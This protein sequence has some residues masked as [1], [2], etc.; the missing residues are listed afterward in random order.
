MRMCVAGLALAAALGVAGV[1]SAQAAAALTSAVPISLA[2]GSFAGL[3]TAGQARFAYVDSGLAEVG[4]VNGDGLA[5]VA[6]GAASADAK[7]R[8][9]A[10]VVYVVF[11][12][13]SL[14][15]IDLASRELVGFRIVGPRQ[16]RRRPAPVF[17][18]DGPPAG[19]MAGS[20]VAGAGD[21]NGDGLDDI[22]VGAPYAGNRGRAYSGSAFVVFG[23]RS[24][25]PVDL[26]RLG[27]AGYRIDGPRRDAAAGYALAGPGDVSGDGRADV[28][29]SADPVGR[30]GVYVVLGQASTAAI[31]L[32]RLAGRGYAIVGG[33]RRLLDVGAAVSG[34]GDFNGDGFADIA[35]GA[36]QS[37]SP[38]REGAGATFVVFGGPGR[39]SVRLGELAG[40]GVRV[41]GEHEFSNLG[42]A[43]ARLGDVNGDGRDD[44]LVGASQVSAPGRSYAGAAYV[45]FGRAETGRLDLRRAEGGAYR[46]LGPGREG[47]GGGIRQGRAGIS[48]AVLGDVNRDGRRDMLI[49]APGAGRRCSPE[50][51]AAYVVFSQPVAAPLDLDELGEAGYAILGG[52]PDANAGSI[53]AGAGDWNLDG[54]GDALVL[55]SDFDDSR[56]PR[57]PLLDLVL[58]RLPPPRPA[59]PTPAQLPRIK[60]P[61]PSLRRLL[62]RRGLAARLAVSESGPADAVLV[63]VRARARGGEF[64]LAAAYETFSRPETRTVR[65][66][67]PR[68]FRHFLRRRSRLPA[69]VVVSQC[70]TAGYEYTARTRIVLRR[71]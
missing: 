30:A 10:G 16:G 70:T 9:D 14:G 40:R 11:G 31:D 8:R 58:G 61:D 6:I 23:K 71:R 27:A 35:V 25:E 41:D 54:R 20:A 5:D 51:G 33:R 12:G 22:L 55:R 66:A 39:G 52:L 59:D 28:L 63:E 32:R 37:G 53:V 21:V 15:R 64:P 43:L 3:P 62:T 2:E 68:L 47:A 36:P 46:I 38:G 69:R 7:G 65:L 13:A 50:E 26:G 18:P 24:G 4:D 34:A 56:R 67:A 48:V 45:I 57:P 44:L 29:V 49:G 42:E 19:A 1:A 17:Q 60:L